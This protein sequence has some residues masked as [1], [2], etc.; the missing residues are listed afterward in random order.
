MLNNMYGA[1]R[2]STTISLVNRTTKQN[3]HWRLEPM[4]F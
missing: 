2:K 1:V 3:E 4:R